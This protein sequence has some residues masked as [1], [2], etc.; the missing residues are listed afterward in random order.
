VE[1]AWRLALEIERLYQS[2][3]YGRNGLAEYLEARC[4][5]LGLQ[6]ALTR[7]PPAKRHD[8]GLSADD[9][10]A[11]RPEPLDQLRDLARSRFEAEQMASREVGRE[12]REAARL[13]VR[14]RFDECRSG[15]VVPN[16]LLEPCYRQSQAERSLPGEE[17]QAALLEAAWRLAWRLDQISQ[18]AYQV[19]RI[20]TGDAAE[21]TAHRLAAEMELA[22]LRE[23]KPEK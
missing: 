5:L 21:M 14:I 22:R 11:D 8:Y 4:F 3:V 13:V 17:D 2:S 19:G 12:W 16:A 7:R 20:A 10:K 9:F 23:R 1:L 15:R 18:S 6:F